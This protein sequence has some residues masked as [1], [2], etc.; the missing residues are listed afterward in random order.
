MKKVK[1]VFAVVIVVI[2]IAASVFVTARIVGGRSMKVIE[3]TTHDLVF[4][5]G[6]TTVDF[7]QVILG[8]RDRLS[9]LEVMKQE[10]YVTATANQDGWLGIKMFKKETTILAVGD[11]IFSV[12][13]SGLKSSDIVTDDENKTVTVTIPHAFITSITPDY[14]KT[15]I[16]GTNG[17]IAFGE[18]K[19]EVS[20]HNEIN[21]KIQTLMREKLSESQILENADKLA[22]KS[23]G[24]LFQRLVSAAVPGYVVTVKCAHTR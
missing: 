14:D 3:D 22:E 8:D 6:K 16:I 21:K 11:G 18:A 4:D 17:I 2:L 20:E 1:L 13:L 23:A 24:E 12:E 5:K 7:G 15:K 19:L 10:V 9:R